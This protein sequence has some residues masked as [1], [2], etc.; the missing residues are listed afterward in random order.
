MSITGEIRSGSE[1]SLM[2]GSNRAFH[3]K[4]PYRLWASSYPRSSPGTAIQG[5]PEKQ[6]S[7]VTP[8]KS[9]ACFTSLKALQWKC[10]FVQAGLRLLKAGGFFFSFPFSIHMFLPLP[11]RRG[12]EKLE[13]DSEV[14][15]ES[16][17][18]KRHMLQ[19]GRWELEIREKAAVQG[20]PGQTLEQGKL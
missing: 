8:S 7:T 19:Q 16:T 13:P 9:L 20:E 2:V 18:G 5:E 4:L 12:I 11:N 1:S 6:N 10:G 14:Q 17:R 15:G 3:G